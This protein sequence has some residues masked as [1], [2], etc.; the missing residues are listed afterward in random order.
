MTSPPTRITVDDGYVLRLLGI[1]D[2]GLVAR[3]VR[4]SL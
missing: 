2:A 4:E 3:S 1:S